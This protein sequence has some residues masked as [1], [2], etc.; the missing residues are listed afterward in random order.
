LST[1]GDDHWLLF[2]W[3]KNYS[4]EAWGHCMKVSSIGVQRDLNS[5][6]ECHL[7]CNLMVME[8]TAAITDDRMGLF[9]DFSLRRKILENRF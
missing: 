4:A 9:Q 8:K 7:V 3:G 2:H 5:L 6:P 1:I